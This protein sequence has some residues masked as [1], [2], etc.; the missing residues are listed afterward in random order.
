M[1]LLKTLEN[2][3]ISD[4]QKAKIVNE[5]SESFDSLITSNDGNPEVIECYLSVF[6]NYLSTT[7]CQFPS[8][9]PGQKVRA[10]ALLL[11]YLDY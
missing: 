8:E 4:D 1:E 6:I 3:N 11:A 7:P 5:I 9:S 10:T 2:H